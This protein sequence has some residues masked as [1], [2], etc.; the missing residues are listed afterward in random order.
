M[1]CTECGSAIDESWKHCPTCGK[2][3]TRDRNSS[4]TT[5][6][7]RA[8]QYS[9]GDLPEP[10]YSHW[11]AAGKPDFILLN[12]EIIGFDLPNDKSEAEFYRFAFWIIKDVD[13]YIDWFDS[14]PLLLHRYFDFHGY[15]M[16]EDSVL[17]TSTEIHNLLNE[18]EIGVWNQIGKPRLFM[19]IEG[20]WVFEQQIAAYNWRQIVNP[21][22]DEVLVLDTKSTI[23]KA[24][25]VLAGNIPTRK[26]KDNIVYLTSDAE[27]K[28]Y[29]DRDSFKLWKKRGR[30]SVV[31]VNGDVMYEAQYRFL[32]ITGFVMTGDL[33]EI[34][35]WSGCPD[36]NYWNYE[37][38]LQ[39]YYETYQAAI[40]ALHSTSQGVAGIFGSLANG[41][42]QVGE[43]LASNSSN[44]RSQM[45]MRCGRQV[46]FGSASPSGCAFCLVKN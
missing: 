24:K 1:Y 33:L 31:V 17:L 11:L 21:I 37:L 22:P 10:S 27:V 34:W 18:A 44:S 3:S 26:K 14:G 40:G 29:A 28:Q 6:T 25:K 9:E 19:L 38:A 41:L 32:Q 42:T 39:S 7:K 30:P 36:L 5:T 12:G 43:Q 35:F 8:S 13:S 4:P 45:C 16:P 20:K 23:A 15:E 2:S 46:A